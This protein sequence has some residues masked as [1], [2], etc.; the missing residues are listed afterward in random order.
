MGLST[1]E[2][3]VWVKDPFTLA[4][5]A[6]AQRTRRDRQHLDISYIVIPAQVHAC[7]SGCPCRRHGDD[8]RPFPPK[9]AG[10]QQRLSA[11]S[12]NL[13]RKHTEEHALYASTSSYEMFRVTK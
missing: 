7:V 1:T 10:E 8:R 6:W 13:V 5:A 11:Y 12:S 3:L 9:K 2:T 4:T